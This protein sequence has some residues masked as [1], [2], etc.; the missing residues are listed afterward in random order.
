MP[1]RITQLERLIEEIRVQHAPDPRM[2]V[3]EIDMDWD[4]STL[5]LLGATSEAAAADALHHGA[6]LLD[7]SM[8]VL[9]R[10]E[11]LPATTA[12]AAI[13]AVAT[14]AVVPLLAG[15]VISETHVSQAV[16]GRRLTVLRQRG[17]WLQCRSD[18]GYLGW[19][20]RG[21]VRLV[22]EAEA[23]AWEVGAGGE[24][25]ISLGAEV[26][27]DGG[28]V[29]GRLPWG[30]RA[31]RL[32][33]GTVYMPN[34]TAGHPRGT[35]LPLAER[36]QRFP[37]DGRRMV[38]TAAMWLGAPYLWGGVTMA[39]VDCSGLVQAVFHLHGIGLPRDSDQQ[40]RTGQPVEPDED[41]GNLQPGDLLYFAETPA[42]ISHVTMSMG[43]SRIIHS[44][45]GNGGVARND[46]L[47]K[48]PFERELREI[49]VCA[50]RHV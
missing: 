35:L 10:V 33:D 17:R 8:E 4:G 40:A 45:L 39:G 28:E 5:T 15:P 14:A 6:G 13:H 46:L 49:F 2:A 1:Y 19:V 37:P 31:L 22:S 12:G 27:D 29:A 26:L 24:V 21:Y 47:G 50:R 32:P 23:R 43:G 34:G 16:M 30:A 3:F 48:V 11:R 36:P 38:E 9:D 44:S 41:F 20:H 42:R 25:C 18:D 7:G